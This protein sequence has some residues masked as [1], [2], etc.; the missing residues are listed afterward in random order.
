MSEIWTKWTLENPPVPGA[1]ATEKGWE[2]PLKGTPPAKGLT[3]VL[4]SIGGLSTR[5]G[6]ANIVSVVIL[7]PAGTFV[8]TETI[9]IEVT[10]NEDVD[11]TGTPQI[12]LTLDSGTVFADFVSGTGTNTLLFRYTVGAS[13][14]AVT[15]PVAVSPIGLNGGTILDSV[16]ALA[17]GLTYTPLPDL[18]AHFIDAVEPT[19]TGVVVTEAGQDLDTG[20]II[21]IVVTMDEATIV[22]GVPQIPV[23]ATNGTTPL[24]GN[25]GQ[26]DFVSGSGTTT[27]TFQYT[28]VSGDAEAT[29]IKVGADIALNGGTMADAAGNAAVLT[30]VQQAAAITLN[31]A[32]LILTVV[33]PEDATDINTAGIVNINVTY[34]EAVVVT[35]IPQIPVFANDGTTPLAGNTGLADFVGGSG[36]TVLNF[37][38]IVDV[39]DTEAVGIKI[40]ADIGLNGGTMA[41]AAGNASDLTFAQVATTL[42]TNQP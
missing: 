3:E 5:A 8:E 17:S 10:F 32:P 25:T 39:L 35:G 18:T 16:D 42:T 38:Y 33:T 28:I 20:A 15:G 21:N 29:D 26:A 27:L 31:V 19:I 13:D 30:F 2:L 36:T 37:Q 12:S 41:D 7:T 40:G 14:L 22:T 6:A 34:D 9:D 4:V 24:A 11:V 1:V 23:F